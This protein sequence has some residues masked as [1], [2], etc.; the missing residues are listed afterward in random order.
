MPLSIKQIDETIS[1]MDETY[2]ANFGS[3]IRNE[4]NCKIVG[5]NL[6]KY[7][8]SYRE[9]EFITVLKWVVR[10]WTLR[11]IILLSKK[12]IMEDISEYY[13]RKIRIL[14]GLVYTWN[15]IFVSEFILAVSME[16]PLEQRI[17]LMVS[18]L[19]VFESRKLSEI[20]SQIEDKVDSR[21]RKEL[22]K[23]FKEGVYLVTKD[24]WKRRNSMLEAFNAM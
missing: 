9:S 19:N 14:S 1:Y 2:D 12:L 15:P 11:S 16:I 18:V 21:I 20:L 22:F 24:E 6:K 3:W 10:D 7:L 17:E 23:K 8:N 4:D 13:Q 5:T